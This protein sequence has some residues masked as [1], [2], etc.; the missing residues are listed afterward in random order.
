M[1]SGKNRIHKVAE[2]CPIVINEITINPGDI[3]FADDNGVLVIP[4]QLMSEV[5]EKAEKVKFTEL[6]IAKAIQEGS[7]LEQARIDY[8]YDQPWLGAKKK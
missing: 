3:I 2:Q 6:N 1:R 7:S 8:R 4:K 5:I